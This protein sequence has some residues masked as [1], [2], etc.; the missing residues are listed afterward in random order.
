MYDG[1]WTSL[2]ASLETA[3]LPRDLI[4]RYAPDA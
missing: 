2:R 1:D 4:E 3:G